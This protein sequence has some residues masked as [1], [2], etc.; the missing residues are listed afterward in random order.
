MRRPRCR[1]RPIRYWQSDIDNNGGGDGDIDNT[2]TAD[3]DQTGPVTDS[4]AV[5]IILPPNEEP[6]VRTPGFWQNPNNGGQFW[7]G[8][9]GNEDHAGEPGFPEGELLYQ[10]DSNCDDVLD[11]TAGLLIGDYNQNGLTDANEDTLFISLAD[12]QALVGSGGGSDGVEKVGRDVVATWLNFLAGNDIDN[13]G[14]GDDLVNPQHFIDDAIDWLQVYGDAS[15]L[16]INNPLEDCDVYS[17][18]HAAV[19]SN[20]AAWN[21]EG[22]LD[23]SAAEIHSALD[24]YNNTGYI[25]LINYAPDVDLLV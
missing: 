21:D 24:Q 18:D 1:T 3:S 15:P 6:G 2:T 7:D 10:V 25:G 19:R 20:S 13:P 8:I 9:P 5:P 23:H 12:A 16:N 11:N 14:T 22:F 17:P 4:A